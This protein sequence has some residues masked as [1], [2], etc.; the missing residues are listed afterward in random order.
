VLIVSNAKLKPMNNVTSLH[1]V[2]FC[3]LIIL[4]MAQ[5]LLMSGPVKA[6]DRKPLVLLVSIDGFRADYLERGITPNLKRLAL[7]GTHAD[8]LTPVF[9]SITFPNHYALVTGMYPDHNGIVNNTMADPQIP[10]QVFTLSSRAAVENPAWWQEGTPIWETVVREGKIASTLFWPGTEA[11]I[12]GVQ[13]NDWLTYDHMMSSAERVKKLLSWLDREDSKRADFAT[14]YFS[15]VDSKGHAFGPDSAEVNAA[16]AEVDRSMGVLLE[17]LEVLNLKNSTTLVIVSDHG[18]MEVPGKQ[19]LDITWALKPFG[20]A[21]LNWSGPI[22]GI[23]VSDQEEKPLLKQL[24]QQ[25]HLQCWSKN[26][27]PQRFH[28][29][30]HR[31]IPS[32][33]CLANPGWSVESKNHGYKSV[34]QHGFDNLIDEMQ[35]LFIVTGP[36][37][38]VQNIR[39]ANSIDIYNLLAH[40]IQVQALPNDGSDEL[41]DLLRRH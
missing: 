17:G 38:K 15:E 4:G 34:G 6:A 26:E 33:L 18:M 31:R 36:G 19:T 3:V 8:R 13:P 27:F 9:P 7:S 11:K 29:G 32:V 24:A 16:M 2:V 39:Q 25:D 1:R 30:H 21:S 20:S 23:D 10:N 37:I 5:G 14:L 12:H 35:G 41:F 40:L 22:A 28:F